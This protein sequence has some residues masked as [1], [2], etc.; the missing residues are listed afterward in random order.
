MMSGPVP[1]PHAHP[2]P[3]LPPASALAIYQIAHRY[4][5]PGLQSL[6]LEHMMNTIT[7]QSAFPL[8]LATHFWEDLHGM[9]EDFVVDH[10]DIVSR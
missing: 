10:F 1:D 4:S 5:L 8:L 7:P 2:T 6:A 9:V 3:E